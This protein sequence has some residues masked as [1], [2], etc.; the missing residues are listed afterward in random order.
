MPDD[1]RPTSL[2][3]AGLEVRDQLL[4]SGSVEAGR[5]ASELLA[6]DLGPLVDE[7]L[8]GGVWARPGLDL[9]TKSLCTVTALLT[10]QRYPYAKLHMQGARNIGVPVEAL[11]G[12]IVQLTFYVGLPV[13]QTGL[14]L[15]A[16]VYGIGD[17]Q[18]DPPTSDTA[19]DDSQAGSR[20]T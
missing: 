20:T 14:R 17:G 11:T 13:V 8:W 10:L 16:E 4:G 1:K 5:A 12:A 6:P 18:S 7:A 2:T 3:E 19:S 15:A 9:Q